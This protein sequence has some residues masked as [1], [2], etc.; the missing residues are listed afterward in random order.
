MSNVPPSPPPPPGGGFPP[1]PHR[2]S[3]GGANPRPR[4]V[5]LR[6]RGYG[7]PA[8][9]QSGYGQPYG[10]P[11]QPAWQPAG[12]GS[13]LGAYLL[14]WLILGVPA[15]VLFV[16]LVLA[17]PKE[18]QDCT[19]DGGPGVCEVPTGSSWAVLILA[20]LAYAVFVIF[21]YWGRLEG[22]QGQTPGKKAVGIRVV[23]DDGRPIGMGR[24]IGR[25]LFRSTVSGWICYLGFLWML[26]DDRSQALHDKVVTSYV[27]RA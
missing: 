19:V 23:G 16:V 17:L 27:I 14:D 21:V 15:G 11:A 1:P 20:G 6:R 26:W 12:F 10:H 13:R 3:R 2:V 9:G 25:N 5:R 8:Y 18:L 4:R 22:Q 24:A 7:Q